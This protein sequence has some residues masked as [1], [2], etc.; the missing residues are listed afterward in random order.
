LCSRPWPC[1]AVSQ[2]T[3]ATARWGPLAG[4]PRARANVSA[5][6]RSH[7]LDPHGDCRPPGAAWSPS[8]LGC[9]D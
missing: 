6:V 2:T 8:A 9:H 5:I 4:Y 1:Q 7:G 3:R